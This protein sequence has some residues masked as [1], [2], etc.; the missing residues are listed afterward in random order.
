MIED[1]DIERAKVGDQVT[2]FSK[3]EITTGRI[4]AISPRRASMQIHW[5]TGKTSKLNR[6]KLA[7]ISLDDPRQK[8][9]KGP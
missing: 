5:D 3:Y 2:K 9:Q 8:N 1:N 6:R 7:S 4:T